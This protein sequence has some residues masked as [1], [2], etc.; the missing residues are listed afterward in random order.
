MMIDD[1]MMILG[2]NM[3][4]NREWVYQRDSMEYMMGIL[5]IR[6]IWMEIDGI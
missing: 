4:F 1:L 6:V 5:D 2:K 3:W